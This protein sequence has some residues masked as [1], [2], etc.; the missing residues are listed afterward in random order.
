MIDADEIEDA[1]GAA[2]E[3]WEPT[4]S[5]RRAPRVESSLALVGGSLVTSGATALVTSEAIVGALEPALVEERKLVK[6]LE[7]AEIKARAIDKGEKT[8]WVDLETGTR[9]RYR[10]YGGSDRVVIVLHDVGECGDVY[11]GLSQKLSERG[12]RTYAIDMRGHGDSSR[13]SEGRYAPSDLAADIESFIVELDLYVRPVAFV[14]FGLGGIVALELAKKNPRLVAST[15]LVECSPLAPA[16]AYSFFPLQAGAY[17]DILDA[18][19]ALMSPSIADDKHSEHRNPRYACVRAIQTLTRASRRVKGLTLPSGSEIW[20]FRVDPEFHCAWDADDVWESI[21]Q[22]NCHFAIVHGE[23]SCRVRASDSKMIVKAAAQAKSSRAYVVAAASRRVVEDAP[24]DTLDMIT[25]ALMR[26]DDDMSVM[27]KQARTPEAL[28]I[29]PLP[30]Y[31][32]LEDAIK[33]L[34]PRPIPTEAQIEDALA[35]ARL[36]DECASDEDE[37]KFANRTKL[38]QNDPEYFGF[39]G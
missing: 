38:I 24:S 3:A 36:D 4:P 6:A 25:Y 39:V 13:S 16:D 7:G 14:G 9:C 11:Y 28:G 22:V 8:R 27:N 37:G 5:H 10:A 21:E 23:H 12:Y 35:R 26:A 18:V 17:F 2:V 31:A 29:R 1:L 33:A 19:C 15:V 30:Q 20:M 34:A 32:T